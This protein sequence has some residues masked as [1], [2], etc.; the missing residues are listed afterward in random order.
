MIDTFFLDTTLLEHL[1]QCHSWKKLHPMMVVNLR[2]QVRGHGC[3]HSPMA[4]KGSVGN[5]YPKLKHLGQLLYIAL[6]LL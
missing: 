6:E 2:V 5:T 3:L 1:Q 4:N